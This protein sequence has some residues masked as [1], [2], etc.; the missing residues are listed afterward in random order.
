[1]LSSSSF[2]FAGDLIPTELYAPEDR[3][4]SFPALRRMD[5]ERRQRMARGSIPG[6]DAAHYRGEILEICAEFDGHPCLETVSFSRFW[7]YGEE[8]LVL[9]R[10]DQVIWLTEDRLSGLKDRVW[11]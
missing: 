2:R 6:Q 5:D 4:Y 7:R 9:T 8:Y 1:M 11:T 3:D 10:G